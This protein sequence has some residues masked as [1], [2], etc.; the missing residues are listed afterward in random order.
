MRSRQTPESQ[1]KIDARQRSQALQ[2]SKSNIPGLQ[3]I[4]D[5]YF[6]AATG[7]KKS[8]G[9]LGVGLLKPNPIDIGQY[10]ESDVNPL[11]KPSYSLN[12]RVT[13]NYFFVEYNNQTTTFIQARIKNFVVIQTLNELTV[14]QVSKMLGSL[15]KNIT[16]IS[17]DQYDTSTFVHP[18]YTDINGNPL[19]IRYAEIPILLQKTPGRL[20]N[21]P[22]GYPNFDST[23]DGVVTRQGP[24]PSPPIANFSTATGATLG[25]T[26]PQGATVNYLD[27]SPMSPWQFAP[28]GWN[29]SFGSGAVPTGSTAQNPS[30]YYGVLGIYTVTL[31]VSNSSGSNTLT[32]DSFVNVGGVTTTTTTSTTTTTTTVAPTT[33]TTTTAP[34]TTTTTTVAPTTTTTTTAAPTT[35]TTTTAA[36]TT[37][38]TTAAPT[39]TT[40]TVAPTTTTTTTIAGATGFSFVDMGGGYVEIANGYNS[41]IT[42]YD[43]FDEIGSISVYGTDYFGFSTDTIRLKIDTNSE[44]YCFTSFSPFSQIPCQTTTTTTT[45]APTTTTTIAPTTTTTTIA[46]TTTTTTIAPTTTTTTTASTTTTTTVFCSPAISASIFVYDQDN[47]AIQNDELFNVNVYN[48]SNPTLLG[49]VTAQDYSIFA[50]SDF[51]SGIIKIVNATNGCQYC[52]ASV[53]PYMSMVCPI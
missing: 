45:I 41:T 6:I 35:T 3:N 52:F 21:V 7:G 16:G 23:P 5:T 33:T 17:K 40:T 12:K 50:N 26:V 10:S 28:T 48:G 13:W 38:T 11:G 8:S 37:T 42:V 39:T 27:L 25:I 22:I 46:P 19:S 53:E 34:T 15:A 43:G 2:T 49:S 51:D 1:A 29:W 14:R 9:L 36:P 31:T 20:D 18:Y 44:I 4:P 32:R 24:V 47:L 30:V